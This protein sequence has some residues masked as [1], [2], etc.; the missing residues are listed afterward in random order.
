MH[1]Q[2]VLVPRERHVGLRHAAQDGAAA[3]EN[4]SAGVDGAQEG[5][6]DARAVAAPEFGE[7][8]GV[9]DGE[10][11]VE[12]R[13]VELDHFVQIGVEDLLHH[14]A[15]RFAGLARKAES[16]SSSQHGEVYHRA[17][18][19]AGNHAVGSRFVVCR[20][21]LGCEIFL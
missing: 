2:N 12:A 9:D 21:G 16:L 6:G 17:G 18:V 14:F 13:E 11:G 10:A 15:L 4:Q 19:T 8:L 3:P 20:S 5:G 1:G 7:G